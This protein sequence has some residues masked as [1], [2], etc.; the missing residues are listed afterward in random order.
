VLSQ[1]GVG[2]NNKKENLMA[3]S[4]NIR[5]SLINSMLRTIGTSPLSGEDTEHPD[6]ITANDVLAEVIEDVS[7]MPLW[8][9]NSMAVLLQDNDG[10]LVVPNNAISCDPVDGANLVV[11]DRYLF[12]VDK[13]TNVISRDVQCYIHYEVDL[14]DMP[15]EAIKFIRA[16]ARYK[17]YLDEDGGAQKLRTYAANA[18]E[19]QVKLDAVNIA[20]MDINFFHSRAAQTFFTRRPSSYQHIG[21]RGG[22]ARVN[23]YVSGNFN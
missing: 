3:L 7:S 20:R 12:D 22:Q 17:F 1:Y 21:N 13:R 2:N 10:R 19:A 18:Y 4:S 9:N 5:I 23:A 11:R 14:A 16:A 15:R 6:Y 8:F